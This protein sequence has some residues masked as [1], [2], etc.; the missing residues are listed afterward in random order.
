MGEVL[1]VTLAELHGLKD[2]VKIKF[3]SRFRDR[4]CFFPF[5]ENLGVSARPGK[6]G[7]SRG[8]R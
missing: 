1:R 7:G 6:R 2:M 8:W 3:V 4:P 5:L